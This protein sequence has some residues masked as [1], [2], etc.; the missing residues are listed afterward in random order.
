MFEKKTPELPLSDGELYCVFTLIAFITIIF[1][2]CCR[3]NCY[4]HESKVFVYLMSPA[5]S[6]FELHSKQVP[7][8]SVEPNA[9]QQTYVNHTSPTH[10]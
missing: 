1:C 7:S 6:G 4:S 8:V 10:K 2:F 3:P 9:K 5:A